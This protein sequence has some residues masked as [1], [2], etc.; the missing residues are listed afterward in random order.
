MGSYWG[1]SMLQRYGRTESIEIEQMYINLEQDNTYL[2]LS[3]P[4]VF[5][6]ESPNL[7]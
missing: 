2:T 6:S 7:N 5:E 4:V 1:T 3:Y